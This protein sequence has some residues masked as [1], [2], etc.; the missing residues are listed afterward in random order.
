MVNVGIVGYGNL[1]KA[2][3][4]E[5]ESNKN[6]NLVGIF[7]KRKLSHPKAH[8]YKDY[9]DFIGNI[10]IMIMC[11]GSD[12]DLPIQS[13][14][15][16]KCFNIIDTFDNHNEIKNH[17]LS[18]KKICEEHKTNA[19]ICSGWDPGLFSCFRILFNSIL[20]HC[21]CFYGKGVSMGHTNALKNIKNVKNAIQYT[22][23]NKKAIKLSNQG[24]PIN[25][26][27]HFRLCYV[28]TKEDKNK[29]K[30]QIKQIPNYFKNENV[31][32][33]FINEHKLQNKLKN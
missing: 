18:I 22:I 14:E 24:K 17:Y 2:V 13:A 23:P 9:V 8:L 19:I 16:A 7:S 25:F 29:I 21:E 1:G 5:I 15:I 4:K 10:N 30:E 27:K 12:K 3:E 11:G 6:F 20:N 28:V 33:K 26:N 32:I 31:K